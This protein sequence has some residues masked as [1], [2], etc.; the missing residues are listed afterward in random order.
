MFAVGQPV[1]QYHLYL[2]H[3]TTPDDKCVPPTPHP[4]IL[5]VRASAD[6]K[7]SPPRSAYE[8]CR[9]SLSAIGSFGSVSMNA[10]EDAATTATNQLA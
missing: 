1:K 5:A 3:E 6:N 2:S 8:V 4:T 7:L 10:R 9:F